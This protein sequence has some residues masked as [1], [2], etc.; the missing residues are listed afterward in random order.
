MKRFAGILGTVLLLGLLLTV[1][2]CSHTP[3][4]PSAAS[5][6]T[7]PDTR[8][9]PDQFVVRALVLSIDRAGVESAAGQ[10]LLAAIDGGGGG[11]GLVADD[12]LAQIR[13]DQALLAA[14]GQAVEVAR[15]AF[16][17]LAGQPATMEILAST[18]AGAN[19]PRKTR[20][21]TLEVLSALGPD[22]GIEGRYQLREIEQSG[23][24]E[25][26]AA[27]AGIPLGDRALIRLEGLSPSGETLVG[28]HELSLGNDLGGALVL[29]VTPTLIEPEADGG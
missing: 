15:P 14:A 28:V 26:A 29:F 2:L 23:A 16:V 11:V 6:Q 9:E 12:V 24:F 21:A 4:V 22:G 27:D 13:S 1:R 19:T 7:E 8:A 20:K 5:A 17:T 25:H 3:S 18:P 10:R